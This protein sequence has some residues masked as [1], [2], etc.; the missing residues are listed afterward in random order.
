[1]IKFTL[2]LSGL[3]LVACHNQPTTTTLPSRHLL[4]QGIDLPT[5]ASNAL[6]DIRDSKLDFVARYYRSRESRWP[7]LT[8]AEAQRLSLLGV[9]IVAVWEWHSHDPAYFSYAS[10]YSDAINAYTQA[11]AVGQPA[12]S[13]IYFAVD[14]NAPSSEISGAIDQYFGGIAAGLAATGNGR[15][16]Y[17]VGVYGSGAVCE[18]M[19]RAGLAQYAWLTNSTSWTGTLDYADWNIRQGGHFSVLS[20]DHDSNEAKDDYGGFQVATADATPIAPVMTTVAAP[21]ADA[22]PLASSAAAVTAPAAGVA[23]GVAAPAT[24]AYGASGDGESEH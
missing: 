8:A 2:L 11:K 18:A 3:L 5:D 21:A 23:T 6:N 20:F 12:G 24:V 16:E 17:K 4:A 15:P 10:G 1:M 14:Y 19:R 22:P 9:N 13:A 7:T